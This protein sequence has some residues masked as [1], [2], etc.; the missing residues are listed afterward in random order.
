MLVSERYAIEKYN[1]EKFNCN[2]SNYCHTDIPYEPICRVIQY[3]VNFIERN[4]RYNRIAIQPSLHDLMY[5]ELFCSKDDEYKKDILTTNYMDIQIRFFRIAHDSYDHYHIKKYRENTD[6]EIISIFID[7]D[8]EKD[9][10]V[11]LS[12]FTELSSFLCDIYLYKKF[13]IENVMIDESNNPTNILF[14]L[15]YYLCIFN[16]V[17]YFCLKNTYTEFI[18]LLDQNLKSSFDSWKNYFGS[19][20]YMEAIFDLSAD[21]IQYGEIGTEYGSLALKMFIAYL[22]N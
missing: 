8:V 16:C 6:T 9:E 1:K 21:F 13:N 12:L 19:D 17:H 20:D 11:Q 4:Y 3:L 7:D 2:L 18:S 5:L 22:D 10:K 15:D 14:I